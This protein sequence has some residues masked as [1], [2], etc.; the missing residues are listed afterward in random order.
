MSPTSHSARTLTLPDGSTRSWSNA[1]TNSVLGMTL[2]SVVVKQIGVS[3]KSVCAFEG[4]S[5]TAGRM[6]IS[7]NSN[8]P[9]NSQ[10]ARKA[11][12][13]PSPLPRPRF[14]LNFA[15][16]PPCP[17]TSPPSTTQPSIKPAN[18]PLPPLLREMPLR[19]AQIRHNA[20]NESLV[21]S[22]SSWE[23]RWR[24][25]RCALCRVSCRIEVEYRGVGAVFSEMRR[26]DLEG[27]RVEAGMTEGGNEAAI[28]M[29]TAYLSPCSGSCQGSCG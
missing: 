16:S 27:W 18:H 10:A 7:T 5:K 14:R 28:L 21:L 2:S 4:V 17:P 11:P 15:L 22:G 29:S 9:K 26:R 3:A 8:S 13:Y 23:R 12:Q 1:R 25:K 20:R 19:A 24:C 6:G